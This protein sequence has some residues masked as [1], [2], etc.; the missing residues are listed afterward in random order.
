MQRLG[1]FLPADPEAIRH[2]V[3]RADQARATRATKQATMRLVD[4]ATRAEYE[5]VQ[6]AVTH[7]QAQPAREPACCWGAGV[8][9]VISQRDDYY[10]Q[11]VWLR[12]TC[13]LGYNWH[14][15]DAAGQ[16]IPGRFLTRSYWEVFEVVPPPRAELEAAIDALLATPDGL[17]SALDR[18]APTPAREAVA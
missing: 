17:A 7:D 9:P 14:R 4:P 11:I 6:M 1:D 3:A 15:R 18:Q 8:V 13:N 12:C 5:Q 10:P 16:P 2:L